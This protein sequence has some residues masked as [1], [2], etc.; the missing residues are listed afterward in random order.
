MKKFIKLFFP[1]INK[2][3]S[4]SY[5]KFLKNNPNATRKERIEAIKKFLDSTR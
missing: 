4:F 1:L 2:N 3:K 5:G